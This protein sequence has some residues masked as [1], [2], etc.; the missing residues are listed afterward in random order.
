MKRVL[1]VLGL[2]ASAIVG[3][4][5]SAPSPDASPGRPD[6]NLPVEGVI[7]NPDWI[8]TPNGEDFATY[9]PRFAS[10]IGLGGRA[11]LH[12]TVG[13]DGGMDHC[14]VTGE[15]PSG[16]GF[17]E[18]AIAMSAVF[19]MRPRTVDG[20]PTSGGTINIPIRFM[21]PA[22]SVPTPPLPASSAATPDAKRLALAQRV[23]IAAHWDAEA[24][25][26]MQKFDVELDADSHLQGLTNEE[27]IAVNSIKAAADDY[28]R[29]WL[30][31]RETKL[32]QSFTVEELA[33]LV[34][35][36]ETSIAQ[37]W[38]AR[39]GEIEKNDPA[40]TPTLEATMMDDARARFCRQVACLEAPAAP[41]APAK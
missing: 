2:L 9:Y 8:K 15:T 20:R 30:V 12:C 32:A 28:V 1:A 35:F 34:D 22:I 4:A 26:A 21:P 18:A 36:F 39:V 19:R 10:E 29:S 23:A 40:I 27:V 6:V 14:E 13:P 25:T 16:M 5:W 3:P 38:F 7:T 41:P 33:K 24:A 11:V 37:T 17:G 31:R